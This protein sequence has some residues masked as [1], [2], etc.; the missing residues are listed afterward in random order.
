MRLLKLAGLQR[1]QLTKIQ[2]TA[3]IPGFMDWNQIIRTQP[4]Y[5]LRNTQICESQYAM[6]SG[7]VSGRTS[8]AILAVP[9]YN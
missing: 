8:C 9:S 5:I 7:V 6:L 2:S 4:I 1:C 3:G